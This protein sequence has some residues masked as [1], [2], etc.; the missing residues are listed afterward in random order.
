MSS[1]FDQIKDAASDGVARIVDR[2]RVSMELSRI[3]SHIRRLE[4]SRSEKLT[5]LG[6]RVHAMSGGGS[7]DQQALAA[8]SQAIAALEAEIA[9]LRSQASELQQQSALPGGPAAVAS[10][11]CGQP[12]AAG[13]KF[14]RSCGANVEAIVAAAEEAAASAAVVQPTC[15][16]CGAQV[17]A[18]AAFCPA[19]GAPVAQ[20]APQ[21]P[22]P[23]APPPPPPAPPP[24]AAPSWAQAQPTPRLCAACGKEIPVEAKF[25]RHCGAPA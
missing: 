10:C 1:F 14:C 17:P 25:C 2:G 15:Q 18:A 24:A 11:Q 8:D 13:A 5:A 7:L 16:G 22:E 6:E 9:K 23:V 3:H 12:L 21:P 19:C 20:T 4:R